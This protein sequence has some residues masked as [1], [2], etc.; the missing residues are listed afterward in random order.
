MEYCAPLG[1]PHSVFLKWDPDDQDKAIAWSRRQKARCPGCGT[2][3]E[4]WMDG[5]KPKEHPPYVAD[6]FK[7]MGCLTLEYSN[8]E[9]RED[10]E[11]PE[12]HKR[13][14]HFFLKRNDP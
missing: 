6:S 7:C 12:P 3:P 10:H 8:E 11:L 9:V 1:I 13:S 14:I 2:I 5:G 4:D